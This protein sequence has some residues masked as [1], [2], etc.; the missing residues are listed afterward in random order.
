MQKKKKIIYS[1]DEK[2]NILK[3]CEKDIIGFNHYY[4]K[5][6]KEDYILVICNDSLSLKLWSWNGQN[7]KD[8][9]LELQEPLINASFL[10]FK[11]G[12]YII[13]SSSKESNIY[14]Y[15]LDKNNFNT[16]TKI[17]DIKHKIHCINIYYE[18][19]YNKEEKV[20]IIMGHEDIC[21]SYIFNNFNLMLY[22]EY[23]NEDKNNGY[24]NSIIVKQEEETTKLIV[25]SSELK[26]IRIFDFHQNE[27][28]Y[29]LKRFKFIEENMDKNL[30]QPL[31]MCLWDDKNLMIGLDNNEIFKFDFID[32]KVIQNLEAHQSNVISIK[33]IDLETSSILY[34][35][36][37]NEKIKKWELKSL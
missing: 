31:S 9:S 23:Y 4:D 18:M 20:Y 27:N 5:N 16:F 37:Y 15:S 29:E 3:E 1:I 14:I 26:R 32:R 13:G 22:K 8:F 2:N 19:M 6:L 33:K 7:W 12:L 36:G 10:R 30:F 17:S 34:S 28:E 11:N 35:Q 24:I 25:C 21:R